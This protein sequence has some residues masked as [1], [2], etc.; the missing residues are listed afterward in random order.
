MFGKL[1]INVP[2]DGV[3]ALIGVDDE[4][5]LCRKSGGGI[6]GF[7]RLNLGNGKRR[8]ERKADLCGVH[9]IN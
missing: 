2:A 5:I 8:E 6:I 7:D 9:S 3:L 1:P 4:R